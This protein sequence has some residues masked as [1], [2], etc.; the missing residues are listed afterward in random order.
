MCVRHSLCLCDL[1]YMSPHLRP[2][3]STELTA[4]EWGKAASILYFIH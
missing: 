4:V 3:N 1:K 2:L